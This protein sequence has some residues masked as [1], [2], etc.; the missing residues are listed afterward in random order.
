M[1]LHLD[2]SVIR[3]VMPTLYFSDEEVLSVCK[4]LFNHL[5]KAACKYRINLVEFKRFFY[6]TFVVDELD[7]RLELARSAYVSCKF[8]HIIRI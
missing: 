8:N 7:F 1:I 4:R 5:L 3:L 2:I 6:L